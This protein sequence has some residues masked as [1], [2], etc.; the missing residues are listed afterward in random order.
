MESIQSISQSKT[1]P[2]GWY[3]VFINAVMG[4]TM[5]AYFSQFSMTVTELSLKMNVPVETL[6]FSDTI[7]SFAIV[8]AMMISGMIYNWLGLK[9]TFMLSLTLLVVPQLMIPNASSTAMLFA[10]KI[11][12]GLSAII[13]PVF[14]IVII[15]WTHKSQRGLATAVFNGIFYGG[16]GIGA[17]IT[18]YAIARMGWHASYVVM[19]A[20]SLTLGVVWLL[21]VDE[22]GQEPSSRNESNINMETKG[23]GNNGYK[24]I[25]RLPEIWLLITI[26][27]AYTWVLQVISVD[28]PIFGE[29]LGYG[30]ESIG[31][32]MTATSVG[33]ILSAVISGNLSDYMASKAKSKVIARVGVIAIGSVIIVLASM[34]LM[35]VDLQNFNKLYMIILLFSFGGAWGL[36]VFWSIVAEMFMGERLAIVTGFAGGIADLSMP[37]APFIVGIIFGAK[38]LW[39]LGWGSCM[40]VGILSGLACVVL[41]V[42]VGN[43]KMGLTF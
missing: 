21:S 16:S 41:M 9:R 17:M 8:V 34:L 40:V 13:F 22:H 26:F 27:T 31:R 14:L 25:I 10:L 29:F 42:G 11:L 5:A 12:Q 6:L 4:C 2:K 35:V 43:D 33:I 15:D 30:P 24:A 36:G 3:I 39:S 20:I 38:G 1:S 23:A 37:I 18:G 32:L 7:K 28:M 19:A